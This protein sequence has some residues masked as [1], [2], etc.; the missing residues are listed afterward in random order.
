MFVTLEIFVL[1]IVGLAVGMLLVYGLILCLMAGESA[2]KNSSTN[3]LRKKVNALKETVNILES[4]LAELERKD[5]AS[6]VSVQSSAVTQCHEDFFCYE[7]TES[8][9][10]ASSRTSR[11]TTAG[12][13]DTSAVEAAGRKFDKAQSEHDYDYVENLFTTANAAYLQ[14]TRNTFELTTIDQLDCY[15]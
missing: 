12:P 7:D 14:H 8:I 5:T 4:R 13:A 6:T 11:A 3:K 15:Q 10:Q 1:G 2:K 9:H